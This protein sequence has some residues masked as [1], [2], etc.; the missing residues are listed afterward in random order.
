MRHLTRMQQVTFDLPV[1]DYC[2]GCP[3][4]FLAPSPVR[5]SIPAVPPELVRTLNERCRWMCAPTSPDRG[6]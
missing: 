4:G 1:Q 5:K 2:C 6:K 3:P